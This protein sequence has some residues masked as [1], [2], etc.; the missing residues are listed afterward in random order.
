MNLQ[1]VL[2]FHDKLYTR[3]NEAQNKTGKGFVQQAVDIR[4]EKKESKLAQTPAP[5]TT[6]AIPELNIS[7]GNVAC[8]HCNASVDIG[9]A[10]ENDDDAL[11]GNGDITVCDNC[12]NI[13]VFNDELMLR[14]PT[15]NE[16]LV[17]LKDT[18]R[19]EAISALQKQIHSR[20]AKK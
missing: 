18:K 16:I 8:P 6:P 12:G 11:P 19:S 15:S 17:L 20:N 14:K 4:R 2:D 3:L 7:I 1:E 10:L 13:A 9:E 5:S